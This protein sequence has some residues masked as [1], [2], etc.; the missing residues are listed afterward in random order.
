M[1]SIIYTSQK[2][3][4]LIAFPIIFLL[5]SC[6][7]DL[8][9]EVE[10]TADYSLIE[11]NSFEERTPVGFGVDLELAFQ[12]EGNDPIFTASGHV[13]LEPTDEYL[14]EFFH[15]TSADLKELE[16]P[17]WTQREDYGEKLK[18]VDILI[19]LDSAD[20]NPPYVEGNN[21]FRP[22]NIIMEV[23][24]ARI[25]SLTSDPTILNTQT[26]ENN[27]D[28]TGTFTGSVTQTV[29]SSVTSSYS[30]T[31]VFGFKNTTKISAKIF[32]VGA[33]NSTE[34]SFSES[35]TEGSSETSTVTVGS[36]SEVSVT[37][38]P[39]QS[40][41][42]TLS[43][44]RG[45][46][47]ARVT[48]DV[49]LFGDIAATIGW[50]NNFVGI[51]GSTPPPYEIINLEDL[52]EDPNDFDYSKPFTGSGTLPVSAQ[53]VF[54]LNN[55]IAATVTQDIELDYFSNAKVVLSNPQTEE[56]MME[57]AADTW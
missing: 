36:S 22:A 9:N 55:I 3:K 1:K 19:R 28:V 26:F 35:D 49:Y 20:I 18:A 40:V 8:F 21:D 48:Y 32:G 27:S 6:Q 13:D 54:A 57:M 51:E 38:D 24:N 5:S 12:E 47:T 15:I 11:S 52:P 41:L 4:W 56:K 37:L 45:K 30:T 44:S 16:Y 33:E 7:D 50:T 17:D 31:T 25:L 23:N 34:L 10:S 46:L 42:A 53:E 29:S 39:G 14:D 2:G 43:A